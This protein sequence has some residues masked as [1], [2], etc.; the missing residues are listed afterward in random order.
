MFSLSELTAS[1]VQIQAGK[2]LKNRNNYKTEKI[3]PISQVQSQH[4]V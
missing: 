3:F 2:D 4:L 1:Q